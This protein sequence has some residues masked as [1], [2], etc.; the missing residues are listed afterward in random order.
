MQNILAHLKRQLSVFFMLSF[1]VDVH[2]F[3]LTINRRGVGKICI[4]PQ[5]QGLILH[6]LHSFALWAL[7]V[8]PL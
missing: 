7:K 4:Q 2:K 8:G 1:D 3:I 5:R 6:V